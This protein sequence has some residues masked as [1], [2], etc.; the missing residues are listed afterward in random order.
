M[1]KSRL[2]IMLARKTGL[3]QIAAEEG[4]RELIEFI[5]H[6][7]S[8]SSAIEIRGFGRFSVRYYPSRRARNPK[9]GEEI[10]IEEHRVPRFKPS[11]FLL[12]CTNN[13]PLA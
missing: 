9:T 6:T 12:K 13:R 3:P 4:L 7:L 1:L 10:I 8:K 5:T 2:A 11:K